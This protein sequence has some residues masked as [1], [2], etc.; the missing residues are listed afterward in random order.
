MTGASPGFLRQDLGAVLDPHEQH[1]A[2]GIAD[3]HHLLLGMAGD[4]RDPHLRRRASMRGCLAHRAVLALE[5]PE[6]EL[7]EPEV[8]S[9][10]PPAVQ[11]SERTRAE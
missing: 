9:H 11:P 7:V 3:R 5:R 10:L 8:A 1:R 6:H 2:V 4:R